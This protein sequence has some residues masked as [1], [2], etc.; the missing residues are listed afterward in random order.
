MDLLDLEIVWHRLVS[1]ASE[2]WNALL[3]TAFST[4]VRESEDCAVA[5]YD[6]AGRLIAQS[7][8]GTPGQ[9]NSMATC[10][11]NFLEAYPADQLHPGDVLISNDPWRTAGHLNDITVVTPVFRDDVVVA[12]LGSCAHALDIGGRGFSSDAQSNYEEGLFIPISKLKKAG[13]FDE[14]LLSLIRSN[15]RSPNLVLGDI[16]AQA[17]CN[18]V[19]ATRILALLDEF[20]LDD[21]SGIGDEILSRSEAV[22]RRAIERIP[23]GVYEGE[24]VSDG[25][26]QTI[27]IHC[28]VKV[29]GDSIVV[30]YTGSSDQVPWGINVPLCYTAAYTSYA[31]KCSL[32]P[33]V[34]NNDGTYRA[35]TVT[36]PEGCL[37]NATPPAAVAGRHIIGNF[38]PLALYAALQQALPDDVV[39]GSSVLW[40]T[41]VQG[42]AAG[43]TGTPKAGAPF[44]ST[45]FVSGGMGARRDKDGLSATSF[46]ANIAMT[47]VEMLESVSPLHVHRK[48]LRT[49]S[50][51]PGQ[52]RGGLGQDFVFTVA[53][54]AEFTVNT[55]NDQTIAPP[56]GFA[57]GRDGTSGGYMLGDK[58]PLPAKSRARISGGSVVL[59]STPGGGGYGEAKDRDPALVLADVLD[60]YVSVEEALSTYGVQLI[61]SPEG[62]VLASGTNG[63]DGRPA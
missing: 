4:V 17:T 61:E 26:D 2:Q 33:S 6:G 31:L 38:Q 16:F 28:A 32:A 29:Q 56:Q 50:G 14:T 37:L 58:R 30:D 57:G 60:G 48:E 7:P 21:L 23:D 49:D 15:V 47:P 22:F 63:H 46:P 8:N 42:T 9:I 19:G 3:S 13:E 18:D 35:L 25:F 41:T 40:I 59:M 51:G 27:T 43:N 62:L 36:A 34:P 44:T 55:M 12:F 10:I 53:G 5:I 39:A 24:V 45:F 54:G 11:G 1:A 20:G 52:H